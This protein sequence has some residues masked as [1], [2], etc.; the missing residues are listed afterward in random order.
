MAVPTSVRLSEATARKIKE[1]ARRTGRSQSYYVREA[2]ESNV[3][4]LIYEYDLLERGQEARKASYSR[5]EI[6]ALLDDVD[7]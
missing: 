2:V 1:L 7:S 5:T 4:R 3:D 6:E